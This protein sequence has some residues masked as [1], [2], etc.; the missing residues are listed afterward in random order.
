[1]GVPRAWECFSL[2]HSTLLEGARVSARLCVGENKKK[3]TVS[4]STLAGF[5]DIRAQTGFFRTA[6]SF[7]LQEVNISRFPDSNSGVHRKQVGLP[8]QY[9]ALICTC[10]DLPEYLR[11]LEASSLR[12]PQVSP[13]IVCFHLLLVKTCQRQV[14]FS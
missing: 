11:S 12:A 13:R 10:K 5:K 1:M 7:F 8:R 14:V 4:H 2:L 9:V 3:C 6:F